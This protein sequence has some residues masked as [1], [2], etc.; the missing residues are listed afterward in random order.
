MLIPEPFY[1]VYAGA[2]R[3]SGAEP[4]FVPS[5]KKNGFISSKEK[6]FCRWLKIRYY[7]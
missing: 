3:I 7:S 1:Q 2:C 5:I 6:D 4:I